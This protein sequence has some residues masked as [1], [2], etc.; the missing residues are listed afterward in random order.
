MSR[1]RCL[2]VVYARTSIYEPPVRVYSSPRKEK[3]YNYLHKV[4][5]KKSQ[6][7]SAYVDCICASY[8]RHNIWKER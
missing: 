8:D 6:Y 4:V 3:A 2:Y 1:R 5:M 7:T